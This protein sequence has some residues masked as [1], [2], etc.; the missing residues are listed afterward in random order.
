MEVS[1]NGGTPFHPPF[2]IWW[3]PPFME[4]SIS[5]PL[6][7]FGGRQGTAQ[8]VDTASDASKTSKT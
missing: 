2:I 4:P 6:A 7:A 8:R 5:T 3:V 1:Q